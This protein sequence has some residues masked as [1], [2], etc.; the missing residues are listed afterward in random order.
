MMMSRLR[1]FEQKLRRVR[2]AFKLMAVFIYN[3][4]SLFSEAAQ[5]AIKKN[6]VYY[7]NSILLLLPQRVYYSREHFPEYFSVHENQ[8]AEL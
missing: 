2:V 3:H 5:W 6:F 7:I 4:L 1:Q 8:T